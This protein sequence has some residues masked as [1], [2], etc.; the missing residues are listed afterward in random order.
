MINEIYD[1]LKIYKERTRFKKESIFGKGDAGPRISEEIYK[2]L[3]N[4]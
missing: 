4:D 3:C 1:K 2:Q